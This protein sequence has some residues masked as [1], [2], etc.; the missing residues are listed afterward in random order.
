MLLF[1][2]Q[3]CE[4]HNTST[5]CDTRNFPKVYLICSEMTSTVS[6]GN[7][8]AGIIR[9]ESFNST[10]QENLCTSSFSLRSDGSYTISRVNF[11][12]PI[13][14]FPESHYKVILEFDPSSSLDMECYSGFEG[15]TE[16][17]VDDVEFS[18]KEYSDSRYTSVKKGSN[19]MDSFQ[20]NLILS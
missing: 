8:L 10:E 18:F 13:P 15:K 16:L 2:E 12:Q 3:Y 14:I 4:I 11:D 19:P 5:V 7:V 1:K 17:I 9:L 20:S 6:S